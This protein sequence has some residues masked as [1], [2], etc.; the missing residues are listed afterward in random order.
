MTAP[1]NVWFGLVLGWLLPGLGHFYVKRPAHGALYLLCIGGLYA[2][3]YAFSGGTAVN[4]DIHPWY[5]ACQM[6]AGP[7][8]ISLEYLRSPEGI[9]LGETIGVLD[10]QTGV[11]YAA[12][13]GVL[14]LVALAELFRRHAAPDAPGPAD[15]M[16]QQ[17]QEPTA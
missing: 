9:N 13:A 14:N 10:H 12:T 5:F 6:F 7:I 8:T 3:G 4:W 2:V 1:R 16:R 11:V 15:T 17:A